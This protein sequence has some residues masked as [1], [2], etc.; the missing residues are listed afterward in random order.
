[1]DKLAAIRIY[2]GQNYSDEIP[3]TALAENIQWDESSTLIDILGSINLTRKGNIQDQIDELNNRINQETYSKPIDGIPKTDLANSVQISLGKADTALQSYTETDPT[4]P[5][6]AKQPNKPTYTAQE[7]GALPADSQITVEVDDTL[8]IQGAAA[9]AKAVGDA[10]D[11]ISTS[12]QNIWTGRCTDRF[13]TITINKT[14][15]LDNPEDFS[16]VNGVTIAIKYIG[17]AE[18][19]SNPC[20]NVNETGN[21]PVIAGDDSSFGNDKYYLRSWGDQGLHFFTYRALGNNPGKWYLTNIDTNMW[22]NLID[23]FSILKD[24]NVATAQDLGKVPAVKVIR[25]GQVAE[26]Q[27]KDITIDNTL[28]IQGAPADAKKVGNELAQIKQDLEIEQA[29]AEV[30]QASKINKPITNPNG[31][32]GQILQTDGQGGTVWVNKQ[33][34]EQIT[35]AVTDWLDN[36]VTPGGST[37]VVDD[38]LSITGAAADAKKTGDEISDLKDGFSDMDD[39]VTVLE[40]GGGGISM[41]AVNLLDTILSEAVY[42]TDQTANIA[43]LKNELSK[44]PP[45]SIS[46]VLDGTALEGQSYSE[47]DFIVTATFDDESTVVVDDYTLV[48]TGTVVAG[49]NTVTIRYRGVTTTCTFIAEAVITYSITYNLSNV[50]SSNTATVVV[51]DSYYSTVL[52][53]SQ[54]YG[55]NGCTVTMGGVDVTSTVYSNMEILITQVTGDVVIT[56]SA[57]QN[58]YLDDLTITRTKG[59]CEMYSDNLIT[60]VAGIASGT[61][62]YGVTEYPAKNNCTITYTITNNSGSDI[63]LDGTLGFGMIN[64]DGMDLINPS[65]KKLKIPYWTIAS[66]S[67]GT[68]ADGESIM[69]TINLLAGYQLIMTAKNLATYQAL[70]VNL[71]GAFVPDEFSGY[72][73]LTVSNL[74]SNYGS[75]RT[76]NFYSDNGET[77]IVSKASNAFKLITDTIS[78]GTYDVYAEVKGNYDVSHIGDNPFVFGAVANNTSTQSNY[79]CGRT[80]YIEPNVWYHGQ[81]TVSDAG[82]TLTGY[83]YYL[84]NDMSIVVKIKEVTA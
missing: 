65:N 32:Q 6:W 16:L 53:V 33:T 67:S 77:L 54:D 28:N 58:T 75:Y 46:A 39:R 8:S 37:I 51:E 35:D 15:V 9:D 22:I 25:G 84:E 44:I 14:V 68:L 72:S 10:L 38:T 66:N 27:Y 63:A 23:D 41:T 21:I 73:T 4:V 42:G 76:I 1:M 70:T 13:P 3:V 31:T 56:A 12:V 36:H 79:A 60:R 18:T 55:F 52:S 49:S 26:W 17:N 20:L 80:V 78:A 30:A 19:V 50:T 24:A 45:V 47:L 43:L 62:T 48:T 5:A 34:D 61:A 57:T 40:Q 81:I 2:D 83:T 29:R 82:M 74:S 69:G 71:L 59:N 64:P 11:S 7:V